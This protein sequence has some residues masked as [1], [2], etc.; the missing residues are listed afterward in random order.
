MEQE[1]LTAFLKDRGFNCNPSCIFVLHKSFDGTPSDATGAKAASAFLDDL[2]QVIGIA[3]TDFHMQT[4]TVEST[5]HTYV[6]AVINYTGAWD[7]ACS[8]VNTAVNNCLLTLSST[9]IRQLEAI[10]YMQEKKCFGMSYKSY[11]SMFGG[12]T[13][14]IIPVNPDAHL[15]DVVLDIFREALPKW[16]QPNG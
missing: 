16:L 5:L 12:T 8:K 9:S 14:S 2:Y 11:S 7:A 15:E 4:V 13:K 10:V 3:V 6:T 1:H